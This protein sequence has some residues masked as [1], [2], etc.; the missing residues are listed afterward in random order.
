MATATTTL[1]YNRF[2]EQ[3]Q[4]LYTY[5]R[6]FGTFQQQQLFFALLDADSEHEGVKDESP[7]ITSVTVDEPAHTFLQ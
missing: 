1:L 4:W 6:K 5:V 3:K 2:N 7:Q